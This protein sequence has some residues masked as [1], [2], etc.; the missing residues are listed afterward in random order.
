MA[1]G[2]VQVGSTENPICEKIVGLNLTPEL[3]GKIWHPNL[4]GFGSGSGAHRV[5]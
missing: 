3:T 4:S 1:M 2:R 5:L